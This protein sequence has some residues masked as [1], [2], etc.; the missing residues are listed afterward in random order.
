MSKIW[1]NEKYFKINFNKILTKM[2]LLSV[3][4]SILVEKYNWSWLC[5]KKMKNLIRIFYCKEINMN[6]F[7][8]DFNNKNNNKIL[9]LL[10]VQYQK[11]IWKFTKNKMNKIYIK[12]KKMNS[13]IFN[14]DFADNMHTLI[15]PYVILIYG[16]YI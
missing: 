13:K 14:F 7:I 12:Q 3:N 16:N 2:N 4:L 5:I 11:N 6:I 9:Y 8:V 1:I 15:Y 10:L